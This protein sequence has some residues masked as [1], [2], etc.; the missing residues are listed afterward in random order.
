MDETRDIVGDLRRWADSGGV[1][2]VLRW[3]P[4]RVTVALLRCDGGEEADRLTT[5]HPAALRYLRDH[6]SGGDA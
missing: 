3:S 6:A 1:W 5:T 4:E 2:R